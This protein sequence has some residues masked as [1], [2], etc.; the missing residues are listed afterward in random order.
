MPFCQE[1]KSDSLVVLDHLVSLDQPSF[2][3]Q[4]I[5]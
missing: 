4:Y 5:G 2:V 1:K 3:S